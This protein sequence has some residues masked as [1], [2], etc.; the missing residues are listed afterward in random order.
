MEYD[1][2]VSSLYQQDLAYIHAVAFSALARGAAPEIVRRLRGARCPIRHV[3]DVGCGAGPLTGALV[4][5]GFEVT[6]IDCST[7]LVAI[8]REVVPTAHLVIASVYDMEIPPCDAIVA[9]GEPLTYHAADID[10]DLRIRRFFERASAALRCG[11]L[12]M[13]DVIER[14]EPSLTGRFWS[15]GSTRNAWTPNWTVSCFSSRC[16]KG[17]SWWK[18]SSRAWPTSY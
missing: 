15:S 16:R 7:E 17:P 14:G 18:R 6:G 11:G 8:A 3:L 2:R 13:F 1:L 5:A 10:A 4:D 12:L 9:L